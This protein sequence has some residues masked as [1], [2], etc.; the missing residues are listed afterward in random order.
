MFYSWSQS[1]EVYCG[2]HIKPR[3]HKRK[4][5][6]KFEHIKIKVFDVENILKDQSKMWGGNAFNK[7]CDMGLAFKILKYL[8]I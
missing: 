1:E 6:D 4:K 2:H 7:S 8:N 5:K 3:G